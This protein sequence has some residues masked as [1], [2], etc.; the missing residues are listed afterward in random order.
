MQDGISLSEHD[1][2]SRQWLKRINITSDLTS[3]EITSHWHLMATF[4]GL[5]NVG[6][7]HWHFKF[8]LVQIVH[9]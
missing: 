7:G 3:G 8:Y 2:H 6:K 5:T 4:D 1:M 9:F